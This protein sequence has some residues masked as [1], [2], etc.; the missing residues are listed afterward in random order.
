MLYKKIVS[1]Y[2]LLLSLGAFYLGSIMLL[3]EG[4]FADFPPEWVG[5]MPFNSWISLALFGM[6]VF[7]LGNAGAAI[8]GFMKKDKKVFV[9]AIVLGALC[10]LCAALPVIL[11]GE[12]YLPLIQLFLASAIQ[13]ALG[14]IGLIAKK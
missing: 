2:A 5:V 12:W 11:L 4:L 10:F 14:L 1:S 3:G 7:G 9:L 6:I 8:H 13:M